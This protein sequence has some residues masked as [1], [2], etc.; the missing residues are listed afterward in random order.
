MKCM[1]VCDCRSII[2]DGS[3]KVESNVVYR[4]FQNHWREK[5]RILEDA[6]GVGKAR[7]MCQNFGKPATQ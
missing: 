7:E 1:S 5:I 4:R 3:G 2:V 6:P